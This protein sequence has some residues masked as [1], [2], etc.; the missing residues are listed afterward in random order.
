MDNYYIRIMLIWCVKTE[1]PGGKCS[2]LHLKIW[3]KCKNQQ[4]FKIWGILLPSGELT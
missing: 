3:G 2:D 4:R 1:K